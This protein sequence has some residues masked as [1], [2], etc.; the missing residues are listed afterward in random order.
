MVLKEKDS[1]QVG[2]SKMTPTV[3]QSSESTG[4]IPLFMETLQ[5][6][7]LALFQESTCSQEDFPVKTSA[8]LEKELASRGVVVHSG[9]ITVKQ[10]GQYD[11]SSQSLRMLQ[12]SL[13]EDSTL[14]LQTLPKS[15]MMRNGIIYQLPALVRL[16]AAKDCLL[17]PTPVSSDATT[18]AI[19]G[20]DDT[21][22]QTKGLPRKVNKNG[23]DGSIGLARLVKMFPTPAS[24]D[25]MDNGSPSEYKRHTP[26]TASLVGG[27]LNP[28]FVEWLMGFPIGWTELSVLEMLSF[29][30]LRKQSQKQ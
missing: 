27:T 22:Y 24:R 23:K 19:I 10:L 12:H 15:G 7:I 6:S 8:M 3:K 13:T 4:K 5:K 26:T 28:E 29:Q 11:Q 30:Q 9:S 1:R 18:G 2:S 17:L 14:S 16:T 21:F 20:K 25:W